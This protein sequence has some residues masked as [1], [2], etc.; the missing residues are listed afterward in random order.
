LPSRSAL[1]VSARRIVKKGSLLLDL[2]G[3]LIQLDKD[4]DFELSASVERLDK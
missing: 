3:L 4:R 1:A 2:F